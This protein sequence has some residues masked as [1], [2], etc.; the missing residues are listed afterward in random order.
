VYRGYWMALFFNVTKSCYRLGQP[1]QREKIVTKSESRTSQT[2]VI[3]RRLKLPNGDRRS[4]PASIFGINR[5][6]IPD[7]HKQ[8]FCTSQTGTAETRRQ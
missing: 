6:G 4:V 1:C 7:P 2:S 3:D 5:Q 8:L